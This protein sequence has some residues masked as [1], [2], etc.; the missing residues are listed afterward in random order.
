MTFHVKALPKAEADVRHIVTY[1]HGRSPQG[2]T[3]W[4]DAYRRVRIR[5]TSHADSYG[6]ADENEHFAIEVRQA[7]FRTRFGRVYRLLFT[8]VGDEVRILRVR[9]TGQAPIE[10]CDV[11]PL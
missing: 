7:L 10:P 5:L 3:A 2:A 1:I 4:L 8:I 11:E 6:Y 9:G